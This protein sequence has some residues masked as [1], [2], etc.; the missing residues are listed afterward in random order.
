MRI[1]DCLPKKYYGLKSEDGARDAEALFTEFKVYI[2]FQ[3]IPGPTPA[4]IAAAAALNPPQTPG[5]IDLRVKSFKL[6]LTAD[7][8]S[9]FSKTGFANFEVLKRDFLARFSGAPSRAAD[10]QS[11]TRAKKGTSETIEAYGDRIRKIATRHG[12]IGN[13]LILEFFIC[14]LPQSQKLFVVGGNPTNLNEA[15][16]AAKRFEGASEATEGDQVFQAQE[17]V[18]AIDGKLSDLIEALSM[19]E[20]SKE[21]RERDKSRDRNRERSRD[22]DRGRERR[23][24]TDRDKY[25]QSSNDTYRRNSSDRD[26]YRQYSSDRQRYRPN[27]SDRNKNR[28]NS[29][30]RERFRQNSSDRDGYRRNSSERIRYRQNSS[31]R[32]RYD[33][34][35]TNRRNSQETNR[36]RQRGGSPY[37][38][39]D[40]PKGASPG[41][42]IRFEEK[43]PQRGACFLCGSFRHF[44]R[45]CSLKVKE[46]INPLWEQKSHPE[47]EDLD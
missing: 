29:S 34:R 42:Q 32:D 38:R 10:L 40:S 9:W 23:I 28:Q 16:S 13:E 11:L 21:V 30:E 18:E 33:N 25:R 43:T 27:S 14:G 12:N 6:C 36:Y 1:T 44:Y 7:A 26:R 19:N 5:D 41:K 47:E 24:S 22:R 45:Q 15:I 8:L 39:R 3:D 37:P 46:G 31:D 2:E 20:K 17:K 35:D 4:E